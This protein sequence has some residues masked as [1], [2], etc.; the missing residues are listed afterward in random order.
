MLTSGKAR[1]KERALFRA[2]WRANES[3]KRPR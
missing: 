1:V 2:D 3:P